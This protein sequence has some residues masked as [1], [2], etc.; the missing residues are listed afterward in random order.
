MII[1]IASHNYRAS[2]PSNVRTSGLVIRNVNLKTQ[3][4][5]DDISRWTNEK[6]MLLNVQKTKN[7][8]FNFSKDSQFTTEIKLNGE[9]IE[10]VSETKLLGTIVTDKLDWNKNT[11]CI[12]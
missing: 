8:V 6:K 12:V 11:D 3:E 5:L 2:I 10:T 1:T 9:T 7:I 4:H